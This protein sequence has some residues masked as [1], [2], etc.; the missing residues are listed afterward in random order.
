MQPYLKNL[1]LFIIIIFSILISACED[2]TVK[3]AKNAFD[4]YHKIQIDDMQFNVRIARSPVELNTGLMYQKKLRRNH[5]MLFV[6]NS[7]KKVSFWMKN[8][9]LKLDIAFF[10][11][12]GELVGIHTLYPYNE[13]PLYSKSNNIKYA[14]EMS[15]HWFQ[16]NDIKVGCKL[17]VKRLNKLIKEF[18]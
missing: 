11:A 13:I 15:R 6:F 7:P 18:K 10:E 14:L 12:D 3:S 9:S 16:E 17:D 4:N 1:N 5:G 2:Q 8:T